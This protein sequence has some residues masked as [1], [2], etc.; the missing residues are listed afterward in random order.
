MLMRS[1]LTSI[2]YNAKGNRVTL[3]KERGVDADSSD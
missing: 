2:D 1:F 3:V